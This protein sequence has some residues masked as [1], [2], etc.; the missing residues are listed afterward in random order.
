MNKKNRT[1]L[2][3]E[4][5]SN[6]LEGHYADRLKA[7]ATILGSIRD[8]SALLSLEQINTAYG[9]RMQG[10]YETYKAISAMLFYKLE[11]L[12][13]T[14]TQLNGLHYAF[15]HDSGTTPIEEDCTDAARSNG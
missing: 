5:K 12:K 11:K 8:Y 7:M 4:L 13:F 6:C 2:Y 9:C 10:T 1:S 14:K 3:N 15:L